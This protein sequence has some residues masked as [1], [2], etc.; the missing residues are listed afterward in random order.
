MSDLIVILRRLPSAGSWMYACH[1]SCWMDPFR[2]TAQVEILEAYIIYFSASWA[3]TQPPKDVAKSRQWCCE[4]SLPLALVLRTRHR[5]AVP[6]P[7]GRLHGG[8]WE[9]F[10]SSFATCFMRDFHATPRE[11]VLYIARRHPRN[12]RKKYDCY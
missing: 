10:A 9:I 2:W 5:R 6:M 4:T 12:V 8:R 11:A 3:M 7:N 1:W